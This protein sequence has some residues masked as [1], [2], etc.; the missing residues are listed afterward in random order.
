MSH[1]YE[2]VLLHTWKAHLKHLNEPWLIYEGVIPHIWI[3][4]VK[5]LNESYCT[6]EWVMWHIWKASIMAPCQRHGSTSFHTHGWVMSHM[7]ESCRTWMSH[8]AHM[9]ELCHPSDGGVMSHMWLSHSS[10]MNRAVR[11]VRD[12]WMRRVTNEY[13]MSHAFTVTWAS[14]SYVW[15]DAFTC[16]MWR[17]HM[18][19]V[20]VTC[21]L[22]SY[23]WYDT[24]MN[25][26]THVNVSPT[27][28]TF[29]CVTWRVHVYD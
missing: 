5:Y 8:V 25:H 6:Y 24:Y 22:L 20:I 7:D 26:V 2:W 16:V 21:D 9:M 19:D 28:L 15:C 4:H 3:S 1:T 29:I 27:W 10:Y 18:C 17:I 13:V 12:K 23:V 11:D 14:R